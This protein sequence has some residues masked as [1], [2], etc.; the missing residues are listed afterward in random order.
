M[1]LIYSGKILKDG[2]TLEKCNIKPNDFLVVMVSKAKKKTASPTPPAPAPAPL[3]ETPAP[4]PVPATTTSATESTNTET[5][6]SSSA[7][8][9][10]TSN[11]EFPAEVLSSLTSMGFPEEMVIACLRAANGNPDVAVEF[12]TNGIP[13]TVTTATAAGTSSTSGTSGG[14][15][16]SDDPLAALRSHPQL[17]QLRRMVQTNPQALQAVLTQIGQQQPDLLQ[18]INANQAAFLELMNQPAQDSAPS[19]ASNAAT[20]SSPSAANPL[21]GL[22]GLPNPG[23]MA[24]M[25]SGLSESEINEMASMMGLSPQQLRATAQAI[26]NMPPEQFQQ[27]MMQAMGHGAGGM[28][29]QQVIRLTEEEMAAVNRLTDMGF[30]RNDAVQAFLACDKNEALAANFLMD[31]MNDGGF[32]GGNSGGGDD[33]MYD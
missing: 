19:N 7:P 18:A 25:L 28:P 9:P 6:S 33:N 17:N 21:A 27:H 12:L 8:S 30:D 31:S 22:G 3:A 5:S 23:D 26:G 20:S 15:S 29:G 24:R 4:A 16:S 13:E 32:G 14:S 2:D 10:A 11:S 1:K